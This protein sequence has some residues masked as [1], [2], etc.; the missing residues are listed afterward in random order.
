MSKVLITGGY[1]YI[2][3]H[4]AVDLHN[5]SYEVV[6]VD[7]LSNGFSVIGD[8]VSEIIGKQYFNHNIDLTD[9]NLTHDLFNIEDIESVIH[10][11]AF[12][13]VGDSVNNPIDY[14]RNN[15]DSLLNVL[16]ASI[17]NGVKTFV[18]SSSCSVY[19]NPDVLPVTE[20][21][22]IK[23]GESPY[24]KT[25]QMCEEICLDVANK[26]PEINI[27]IL[28]YFNPVG[29]HESGLIGDLQL[30]PQSLVP[31]I[32]KE[33]KHKLGGLTVHG[34]DYPTRDGSCIRDYIH[35]MDIANAHTKALDYKS[36][37]NYNVF[38]IGSGNGVT[39]LELIKT[40]ENVTGVNL[41]YNIGPRRSGDVVAVYSDSK[42]AFNELG[43]SLNR[44]IED[45]MSSA[46]LW[47]N[48]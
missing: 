31:I 4:T 29:A 33:A 38:N 43:W 17:K 28:R 30:T 48:R 47:E 19:G 24:A 6:S 25:K 39:V 42:K 2:G 21:T 23:Q 11:A 37:S 35:V 27:I 5:N 20:D 9:A 32:T 46:W 45:M 13:S 8:G 36:L 10:F 1:G 18:F 15:I 44:T 14:Y 41:D 26:H 34:S 22:P 12:K 40:F 3:S 16:D 7:N